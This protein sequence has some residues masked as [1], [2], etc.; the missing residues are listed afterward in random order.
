MG[1]LYQDRVT[2][3]L[4]LAPVTWAQAKSQAQLTGGKFSQGVTG[5]NLMHLIYP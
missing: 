3:W 4:N 2:P 5:H 1:L